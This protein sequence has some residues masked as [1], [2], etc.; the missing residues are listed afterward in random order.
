MAVTFPKLSVQDTTNGYFYDV[1]IAGDWF[2]FHQ[3]KLKFALHRHKHN[4]KSRCA[5]FRVYAFDVPLT[6]LP[7]LGDKFDCSE[8][9][10]PSDSRHRRQA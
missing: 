1:T 9:Y 7:I 8:F 5:E 6:Q 10:S 3:G 2:E 4:S